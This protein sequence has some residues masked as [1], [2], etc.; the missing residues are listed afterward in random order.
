MYLSRINNLQSMPTHNIDIPAF[1]P[2]QIPDI[3]IPEDNFNQ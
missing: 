3:K 1:K 2:I